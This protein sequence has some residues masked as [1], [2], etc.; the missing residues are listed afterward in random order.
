MGTRI[1]RHR[2]GFAIRI[3]VILFCGNYGVNIIGI[4]MSGNECLKFF[5]SFKYSNKRFLFLLDYETLLALD[6]NSGVASGLHESTI[7]R[8]PVYTIEDGR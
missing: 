7:E 1:S 3:T 4:L 2:I 8:F 6:E 5:K